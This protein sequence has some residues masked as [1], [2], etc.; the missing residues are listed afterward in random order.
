MGRS[1]CQP[2]SKVGRKGGLYG[3]LF[4]MRQ[5]SPVLRGCVAVSASVCEKQAQVTR[6]QQGTVIAIGIGFAFGT[7]LKLLRGAS[8]AMVLL[9][10]MAAMLA[11]TTFLFSL[12]DQVVEKM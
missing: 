2:K 4:G 3:T 11:F 6:A 8:P 12:P 10:L 5:G 1:V 7:V 9:Y